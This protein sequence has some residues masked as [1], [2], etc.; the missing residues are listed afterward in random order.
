MRKKLLFILA[1]M[2]TAATGSWAKTI[3]LSGLTADC[4]ANDGD[5]LTGTTTAYKVTIAADATV[6]LNN[7]DINYNGYDGPAIK[8]LG[9][10][11]IILADGTTNS[12]TVPDGNS[13]D[14]SGYPGILAG[15]AGTTLIIQGSTGTLNVVGGYVA[16]GIGCTNY[17]YNND[18]SRDT[19]GAH[20]GIIQ[21][22]GGI[23]TVTGGESGIGNVEGGGDDACD[24][25]IIN[26]GTVTAI[27]HSAGIGCAGGAVGYI[28]INGGTVTATGGDMCAGIGTAPFATCG[29]ITIA[30]T[31]TCVTATKGDGSGTYDC[32]GAGYC[33]TCGTVTIGG[34][35]GAISAKS[36]VYM[37]ANSDGAGNYW[38]SYYNGTYGYT[39]DA[40]TTIYK[41]AVSGD[42]V[43]LSS[44]DDIPA[45]KAAILKS[46]AAN[47]S[48]TYTDSPSADFTGNELK[49]GTTVTAGYDA[50]TLSRGSAG[51]GAVGFY[52][53][54]GTSLNGNKA[55]LEISS[56]SSAPVRGFISFKEED[57]TAIKSL[58]P[59]LSEGKGDVY[60]LMGRRVENPTQGIYIVNGK[61]VFIK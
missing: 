29:D 42:I 13:P 50:Y 25:I 52:K 58:T 56:S 22:D 4:T 35:T 26:G 51:T 21:I 54:N 36:F 43:Q 27:G 14:M 5:V 57:A 45:D 46:T 20:C 15:G 2:L 17:N 38:S 1:L 16:A 24:G 31:V 55:H 32:I 19:S 48:L 47:I 61:K 44:V 3:D 41:G 28:T 10:A 40:N 18:M 6:T 11:T 12:V 30:N 33:G 59:S 23:I 9:N 39:A 7:A 37:K 53:F 34:T 60:D 49:G 8:C